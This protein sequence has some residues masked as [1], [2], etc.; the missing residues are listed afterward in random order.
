M[1]VK[2][3][4]DWCG[5]CRQVEAELD[6]LAATTSNLSVV[7]ID[8]ERDR[9]L[10]SHYGV[11]SIPHLV[12]F[13]HGQQVGQFVGYLKQKE[14]KAWIGTTQKSAVSENSVIIKPAN[15]TR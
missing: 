12:L 7:K 1:L 2:F 11:K 6:R 13:K 8:I 10:A 15:S 4:A 5:P 14:L 3:G 9:K